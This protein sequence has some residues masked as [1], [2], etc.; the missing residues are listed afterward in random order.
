M[1]NCKSSRQCFRPFSTIPCLDEHLAYIHKVQRIPT[2]FRISL[3]C[4][5]VELEN[6]NEFFDNFLRTGS[7]GQNL[8]LWRSLVHLGIHSSHWPA[9]TTR[10]SAWRNDQMSH[11]KGF[12]RVFEVFLSSQTC[13]LPIHTCSHKSLIIQLKCKGREGLLLAATLSL[14]PTAGQGR[15]EGM[16]RGLLKGVSSA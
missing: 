2:Q 7:L 13:A 16:T 11:D 14:S 4:W 9:P 12:R 15:E 1:I 6:A 5:R 10:L 3:H 8:A